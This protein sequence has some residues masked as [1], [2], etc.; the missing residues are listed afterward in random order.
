MWNIFTSSRITHLQ[1]ILKLNNITYR[2]NKEN[3]N[4]DGRLDITY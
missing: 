2:E 3:H 4:H 1:D